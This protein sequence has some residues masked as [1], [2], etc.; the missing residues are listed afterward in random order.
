MKLQSQL[1]RRIGETVYR[2]WYIHLRNKDVAELGWERGQKLDYT[3]SGDILII[4]PGNQPAGATPIDR[5][6]RTNRTP[7]KSR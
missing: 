7:D 4:R 3:L 6:S 2:K 1:N 5:A